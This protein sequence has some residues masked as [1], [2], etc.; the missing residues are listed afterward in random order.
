MNQAIREARLKLSKAT[1]ELYII[2]NN[3]FNL[4]QEF[5]KQSKHIKHCRAALDTAIEVERKEEL[6]RV[7]Q[8]ALE[9]LAGNSVLPFPEALNEYVIKH[10]IVFAH[11]ECGFLHFTGALDFACPIDKQ[12]S[13][14]FVIDRAGGVQMGSHSEKDYPII[15]TTKGKDGKQ[16][17]IKYNFKG[18]LIGVQVS[19]HDN[20]AWGLLFTIDKALEFYTDKNNN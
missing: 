14:R 6:K 8:S 7:K 13:I 19:D 2:K 18:E 4:Q 15:E 16:D 1:S 10:N 3:I 12:D 20:G 11:V 5:T 17:S 9:H